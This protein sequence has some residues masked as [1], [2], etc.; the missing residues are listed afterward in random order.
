MNQGLQPTDRTVTRRRELIRAIRNRLG[1]P[2]TRQDPPNTESVLRSA[3]DLAA[4]LDLT[5]GGKYGLAA[6]DMG[7][8]DTLPIMDAQ[9]A[10][11]AARR[12]AY[13]NARRLR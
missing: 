8:G 2:A 12:E 4:L 6:V 1:T 13:E 11:I 5:S 7:T 10:V 9:A 3:K